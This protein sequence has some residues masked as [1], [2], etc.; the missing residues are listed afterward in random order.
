MKHILYLSLIC[1]GLSACGSKKEAKKVPP[2]TQSNP[3]TESAVN[4]ITLTPAAVN[5]IGIETVSIEEEAVN[6][7]RLFSAEVVAVPGKMLTVTAPV[8]GT[9]MPSGTAITAG[10][11]LTK[12][13]PMYRF[14]ILPSE[15]DMLSAQQEVAQR[16]VQLTT[17]T[18]KV[19][20]ATRMYEEK[21]GS[22]RGKQEAEA[23][24][25]TI[26]SALNVA[27][28]RL[29]LLQGNTNNAT[30]KLSTL[31]MQSPISGTV[32]KVYSSPSQVL[33]A[34]APIL[35]IV[36]LDPVWV[37]VPLYAG[38]EKSVDKGKDAIVQSLSDNH[39][40]M[41]RAKSIAGPQTSDPLAT[42]VDLYYELENSKGA[43][44]PGQKIS[45]ILTFNGQSRSLA[46]PYSAIVYDI[47]GGTWVYTNPAENTYVRKRVEL[48]TVTDN[49]AVI[50]RGLKAGEKIVTVGVA[51]LFGTEF[52]GGK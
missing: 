40:S 31:N 47:S 25:A 46:I 21:S 51:E 17:A 41:V 45:V 14:V 15:K 10:T 19:N 22:L 42:S 32:L 30:A 16:Q 26:V 12:G 36:A 43:F 44:R 7:S 6:N 24:L 38:D 39:Q 28:G 13:Q 3:T 29:E 9:L 49:K 4:S 20:R 18:E 23:E 33:S 52:G 1:W 48:Q 5:R 37:R 2:A 27:K 11:Q 35:D 50:S 34:S 8:A